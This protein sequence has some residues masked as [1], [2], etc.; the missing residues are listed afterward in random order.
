[1]GIDET[2]PNYPGNPQDEALDVDGDTTVANAR[3]YNDHD[4]EL[5]AH[6]EVLKD[7]EAGSTIFPAVKLAN[8]GKLYLDE[9]GNTYL[10]YNTT[11]HKLEIYIN[12]AKVGHIAVS[13]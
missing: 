2:Y 13:S 12:G 5:L 1:M 11:T 9:S 10:Q 7:L 6:Q 3:D 8:G 4:R